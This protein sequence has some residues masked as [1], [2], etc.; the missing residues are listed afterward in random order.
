MH[1]YYTY[2]PW[3]EKFECTYKT[4]DRPNDDDILRAQNLKRDIKR[5]P[6][7]SDFRIYSEDS[8]I[9]FWAHNIV[10][11]LLEALKDEEELFQTG[12]YLRYVGGIMGCMKRNKYKRR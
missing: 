7:A 6:H 2:R 11:S 12:N 3:L 1:K 9:S 5:T 8:D 10:D 4:D